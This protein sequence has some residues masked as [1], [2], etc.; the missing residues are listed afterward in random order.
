MRGAWKRRVWIE[1]WGVAT[2]VIGYFFLVGCATL[3]VWASGMGALGA[4]IL[5]AALA[6]LLAAIAWELRGLIRRYSAR[7]VS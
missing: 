6:L 4:V 7:K 1:T 2:L 3:A 5:V